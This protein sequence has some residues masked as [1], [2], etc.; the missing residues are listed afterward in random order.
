M[1]TLLLTEQLNFLKSA[2]GNYLF[3][4]VSLMVLGQIL[5]FCIGPW[6]WY[7]DQLKDGDR[8]G[9]FHLCVIKLCSDFT[10]AVT[11]SCFPC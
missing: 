10:V 4:R 11:M 3:P 1:V 2:L 7:S 9:V 6:W 5:I 8:E